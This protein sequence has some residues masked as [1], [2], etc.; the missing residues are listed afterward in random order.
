MRSRRETVEVEAK[1]A[2]LTKE[3]RVAATEA[4]LRSGA[5]ETLRL[6][7][8]EIGTT[9]DEATDVSAALNA[10]A[11]VPLE[12]LMAARRRRSSATSCSRRSRTP[13]VNA[14]CDPPPC[15]ARA[16]VGV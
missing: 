12:P 3:E 11:L 1:G 9:P 8:G 15:K 10:P 13:Q 16:T 2:G 7:P 6:A 4:G 14:P 5:P